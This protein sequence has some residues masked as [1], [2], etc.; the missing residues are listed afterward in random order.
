MKAETIE[1]IITFLNQNGFKATYEDSKDSRFNRVIEFEVES[2]KYYIEWWVN[3]CYLK[4]EN[5][6]SCPHIPFKFLDINLNSPN[7]THKKQLCFYD[8]KVNG[9]TSSVFYNPRPFGCFKIP[10]N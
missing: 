7:S 9:D 4:L 10:F 5:V 6:F 1:K 3:Q 2:K 8:E